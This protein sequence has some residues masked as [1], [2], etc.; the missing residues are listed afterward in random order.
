MV[1]DAKVG[2]CS[3]QGL[4]MREPLVICEWKDAQEVFPNFGASFTGTF[5]HYD[6]LSREEGVSVEFSS[7]CATMSGG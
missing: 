4:P 6:S 5:D 3:R 1:A 7:G 2:Q